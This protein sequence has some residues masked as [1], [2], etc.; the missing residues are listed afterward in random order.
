MEPIITSILDTDLYKIT[1]SKYVM[2]NYPNA[3]VEYE[4]ICRNKD[5]KLGFLKDKVIEQVNSLKDVILTPSEYTYLSGIRFLTHDYLSFL[6]QYR[7]NPETQVFIDNK[8][9]DLQIKIK[10]KWIDTIF[11]EVPVLA[12]VNELYFKETSKFSEVKE[13]GM[14]NLANKIGLIKQHPT[15]KFSDFGTRRR[16]SRDWQ[17]YV[18]AELKANCHQ[19][20]GTS[21]VKLAMDLG[22]TPVGTM[23]HEIVMC[24]LSLVDDI[25][26]AQKRAFYTWM[27]SYGTDN[28]IALSDTFTTKAF[29]KDFDY[30]LA[31]NYKGTRSDSGNSIE[32]GYKMIEHYIK[33]GID[34]KTKTIVFSDSLDIPKA[35]TIFKEFVGLIG[36]SFGIGTSLTNQ[37]G[38]APLN[39]VIKVTKCLGRPVVKLSDDISKAIGD[40]EMI[41]KIKKIYDL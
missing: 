41:E 15:F 25:K 35:I 31:N 29:F 12:I 1:M 16:Y 19:L 3:D 17:K 24:H 22:L 10:G 34:P 8:D 18:V 13:F 39:I 36:V 27:E 37:L 21:N 4:F 38:V 11:Y 32:F 2:E 20:V 26:Q 7:F 33:L 40:L 23:A 28:G 5:V 14:V 6:N 30:T 9:G